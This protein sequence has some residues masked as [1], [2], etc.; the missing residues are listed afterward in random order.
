M[1][2]AASDLA[3]IDSSTVRSESEVSDLVQFIQEIFIEHLVWVRHCAVSWGS[4]EKAG[5]GLRDRLKAENLPWGCL[6]GGRGATGTGR[7][8][9]GERNSQDTRLTSQLPIC[10][11]KKT[12]LVASTKADGDCWEKSHIEKAYRRLL[13]PEK[14][15]QRPMDLTYRWQEG[16]VEGP[17]FND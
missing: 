6:Q 17:W 14:C 15:Y 11:I 13:A 5:S 8:V 16:V 4:Q 9:W 3:G 7:G 12:L 2:L 10:K 1:L